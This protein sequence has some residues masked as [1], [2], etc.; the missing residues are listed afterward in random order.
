MSV[1][2]EMY[3][4]ITILISLWSNA[5]YDVPAS[6]APSLKYFSIA[7]VSRRLSMLLPLSRWVF[8]DAHLWSVLLFE[9][10]FIF[11][12]CITQEINPAQVGYVYENGRLCRGRSSSLRI[13]SVWGPSICHH[14]FPFEGR[15]LVR[16]R[17]Q[18][19]GSLGNVCMYMFK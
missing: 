5:G 19:S 12:A 15:E 16:I 11:F 7:S 6:V 3:K 8:A 14:S 10:C 4:F 17:T 9:T 13:C 2:W 1:S 18:D